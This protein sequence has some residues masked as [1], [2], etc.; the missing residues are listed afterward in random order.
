MSKLRALAAALI[1]LMSIGTV[2][3]GFAQECVTGR[4][5]RGFVE[6]REVVPFPDAARRAGVA[7]QGRVLGGVQL[8]RGKGGYTYRGRVLDQRGRV[9]PLE[10][11]AR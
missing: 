11:P 2:S 5:G 6:R 3:E 4:A 8:C 1:V 7:R 10:I 9:R